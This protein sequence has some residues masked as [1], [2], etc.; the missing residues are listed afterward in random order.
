MPVDQASP[1]ELVTILDSVARDDYAQ[2]SPEENQA[3]ADRIEQLEEDAEVLDREAVGRKVEYDAYGNVVQPE[4]TSQVQLSGLPGSAKVV[5]AALL[6]ENDQ[7]RTFW[8]DMV[9]TPD[10]GGES[11][12]AGMRL[13]IRKTTE[14]RVQS[15]ALPGF[16]FRVRFAADNHKHVALAPE[17]IGDSSANHWGSQS[18]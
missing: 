7:T 4:K 3:I 6:G 2:W 5:Q 14:S 13:I 11:F 17:E 15:F 8:L 18:K 9:V 10:S 1:A 16:Q 12:K